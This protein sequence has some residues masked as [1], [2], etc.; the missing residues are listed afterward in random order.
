MPQT[1]FAS[2]NLQTVTLVT[3]QCREI[4]FG[5]IL[6]RMFS[7]HLLPVKHGTSNGKYRMNKI[8]KASEGTELTFSSYSE[9]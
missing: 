8:A 1:L 4:L 5:Q 7:E 2:Q 6:Q 3:V 9:Q